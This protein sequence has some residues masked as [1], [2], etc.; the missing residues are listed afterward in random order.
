MK[1]VANLPQG[2]IIRIDNEL[3]EF[4]GVFTGDFSSC[5]IF[6]ISC[7]NANKTR[8]SIIH[9]DYTINNNHLLEEEAWVQEIGGQH[10][11]IV[12]IKNL[13]QARD[14]H[15]Q[16]L[17]GHVNQYKTQ[18]VD[19]STYGVVFYSDLSHSTVSR[20]N[21]LN[22]LPFELIHHPL[23]I[24]LRYY[25]LLNLYAGFKTDW[26][27]HQRLIFD[28]KTWC[29]SS[30]LKE[31][32]SDFGVST[33][34][35]LAIFDVK[36]GETPE[37]IKTKVWNIIKQGNV[38]G[39]VQ[40]AAV[41]SVAEPLM[42][43]LYSGDFVNIFRL[44][45][46][47]HIRSLTKFIA[48]NSDDLGQD[49]VKQAFKFMLH[50]CNHSNP[51]YEGVKIALEIHDYDSAVMKF[52]KKKIKEDL[53]YCLRQ[54]QHYLWQSL[55]VN[56]TMGHP[57]RD[58][59]C[60]YVSDNNY[61]KLVTYLKEFKISSDNWLPSREEALRRA[62]SMGEHDALVFFLELGNIDVNSQE[63]SPKKEPLC[64]WQSKQKLKVVLRHF[65]LTVQTMT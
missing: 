35:N 21:M 57:Y 29:T 53:H 52:Y 27:K 41:R 37:Q 11:R 23:E 55:D 19:Q 58:A 12:I 39:E 8:L 7:K 49:A 51:F 46:L 28:G 20:G 65:W 61:S 64:I 32:D 56:L 14:V 60:Q 6:F 62:A 16:I 33:R 30:L 18:E 59:V 17:K 48:E 1:K 9:A 2:R 38:K 25:Y 4:S 42:G 13:P 34:S 3:S 54:R 50:L 10:S 36:F 63:S 45:V 43:H 5:N 47:D 24:S 44:Y 26:Q 31:H 40:D 15:G 22:T